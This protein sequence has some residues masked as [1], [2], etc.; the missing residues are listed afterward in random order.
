MF[1]GLDLVCVEPEATIRDAIACI[2]L[3][4]RAIALVVDRSRCLLDTITDGDIRRAL[5]AGTPLTA[6]V[7]SLRSRRHTCPYPTPVTAHVSSD[8]ADVLRMM[9]EQRLRQ[10]PLLNDRGEVVGLV[11]RHELA[12]SEAMSVAA[13]VMAGGQ[14]ARLRPLTADT[15]KPMLPVAGRPLME[16]TIARLKD[17]GICRVSIATHYQSEKIVEHFGDGRAFGVDLSYVN[18]DRPLGTA[19]AL[20]LMAPPR[21]TLLVMNGDI[22]TDVDFRAMHE[23]HRQHHADLTVAVRAYQFQVP[24]GVIESDGAS[25]L[26]L[27]EKPELN[28]FVNAGIYLLEPA[29]LAHIPRGI[30]FDM[31]DLIRVSLERGSTVVSFL[32]HEYWLDIGEPDGYLQAQRDLGASAAT[33]N[34]EMP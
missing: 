1:E 25:V 23:Y 24:Y 16:R 32:V 30:H 10:I 6:P 7:G 29:M 27:R 21:E 5:L 3:T 28:F 9:D 13:V 2:D 4:E 8:P 19:G 26:G 14:G 31:T 33:G 15:P 20:A 17:A 22:V 11:M 18:E 12:P 34:R